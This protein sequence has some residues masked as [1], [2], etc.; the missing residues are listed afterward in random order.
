MTRAVA[1]RSRANSLLSGADEK[2]I[3]PL[4]AA[5]CNTIAG[6]GSE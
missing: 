1:G 3:T 6:T 4:S 5:R 2:P